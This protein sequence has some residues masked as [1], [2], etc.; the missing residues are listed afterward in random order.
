M[1]DV[2]SSDDWTRNPPQEETILDPVEMKLADLNEEL[3]W[4]NQTIT[5]EQDWAR[6]AAYRYNTWKE[7]WDSRCHSR[8]E[9]KI[10]EGK[11]SEWC[12]EYQTSEAKL[13]DLDQQLLSLK[14]KIFLVEHGLE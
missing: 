12:L 3:E 10:L 6:Y 2:P 8:A 1:S 11:L 5:K 4:V 13:M 14:W 9:A 7:E